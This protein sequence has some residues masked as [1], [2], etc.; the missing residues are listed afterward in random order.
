[1]F[2]KEKQPYLVGC[3]KAKKFFYSSVKSDQN[4]FIDV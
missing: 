3:G 2:K 1:M 4:L